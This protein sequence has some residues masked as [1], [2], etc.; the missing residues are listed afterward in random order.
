MSRL[1]DIIDKLIDRSDLKVIN[2]VPLTGTGSVSA[3]G[4]S[5]VIET[6]ISSSIPSGYKLLFAQLR[7]TGNH[8]LLFWFFS[9]DLTNPVVNYRVRNVGSSAA[10]STSVSCNIVCIKWGGS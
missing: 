2:N 7:G 6:D 3:G 5:A 4:T 10:T 1:Y 9:Y 8:N